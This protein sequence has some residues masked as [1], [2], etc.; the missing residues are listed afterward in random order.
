MVI[1]GGIF[2]RCR[3]CLTGGAGLPGLV[4]LPALAEF[5]QGMVLPGG[6]NQGDAAGQ[7]VVPKTAGQ[8]QGTQIQQVDEVGPGTQLAVQGDGIV[9]YRV[10]GI[11]ARGGG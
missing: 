6:G 4:L 8:G 11:D 7:A 1:A 9:A 3:Q 5:R 10:A 2:F